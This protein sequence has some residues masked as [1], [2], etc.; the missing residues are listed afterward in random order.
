[1]TET[2]GLLLEGDEQDDRHRII[3]SSDNSGYPP[4]VEIEFISIFGRI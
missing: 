1:M 3:A 4:Y 2:Y